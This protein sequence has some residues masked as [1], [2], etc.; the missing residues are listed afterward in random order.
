M[1]CGQAVAQETAQYSYDALG[2]LVGAAYTGGPRAGKQ[3]GLAYDPA[4]NR[5]AQASGLGLPNPNNG[6][7][8]SITGPGTVQEGQTA[9]FTI[10]KSAPTRDTLTVNFS[11]VNGTASAPGDFAAQSGTLSFLGWETVKTVLVQII[12]DG[13]S[14]AAE[15]FSIQLSAPASPSTIAVG[16]ATAT[17]AANGPA[18]QPPVPVVDVVAG[19]TCANVYFIPTQNDTDPE[20]NYPL[21][22]VSIDAT[23][24]G[25]FNFNPATPSPTVQ[26]HGYGGEG[27]QS[28]TYQVRDSLG[29]VATGQINLTVTDL[30]GCN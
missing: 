12:D 5:T 15:A 30:G 19:K 24:L 14:E 9:V 23:G 1:Y 3:N 18:N 17:I 21:Y 13:I 16:S 27:S 25:Y 29:A 26:F 4:G 11:T 20:G 8:W 10:T 22:V 7:S 28:L 6:V 2:R